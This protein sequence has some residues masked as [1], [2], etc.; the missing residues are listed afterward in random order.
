MILFFNGHATSPTTTTA[1]MIENVVPSKGMDV[2][3]LTTV[4]RTVSTAEPLIPSDATIAHVQ[5]QVQGIGS[6]A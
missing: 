2:S 3:G 6:P 1:M 4:T 5:V